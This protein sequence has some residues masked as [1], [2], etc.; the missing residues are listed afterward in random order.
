MEGKQVNIVCGKIWQ[1]YI[2]A[3]RRILGSN[4]PLSDINMDDLGYIRHFYDHSKICEMCARSAEEKKK[5][6]LIALA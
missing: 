2:R 5:A 1:E 4:I 6:F 3:L